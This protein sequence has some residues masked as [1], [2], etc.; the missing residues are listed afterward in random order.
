[1]NVEEFEANLGWRGVFNG[2]PA[3]RNAAQKA[4]M[5]LGYFYSPF[6]TAPQPLRASPALCSKCRASIHSFCSKNKATKTWN[7]SFC[8][9]G[10][11]MTVDIG[12]QQVEEYVESKVG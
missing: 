12:L 6:L 2:V 3:T 9:T 4:I 10:N 8:M 1:M 7:C 5:P 11:P